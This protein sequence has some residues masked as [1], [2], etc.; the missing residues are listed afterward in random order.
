MW[1]CGIRYKY[2]HYDT[3]FVPKS[4]WSTYQDGVR[5]CKGCFQSTCRNAPSDCSEPRH[6]ALDESRHK[7]ARKYYKNHSDRVI[8]ANKRSQEKRPEHYKMLLYR[9]SLK[10]KYGL[11]LEDIDRML[12]KQDFVCALCRRPFKTKP[13]VDHSHKTGKVRGLL[14][15]VCNLGVGWVERF[16]GIDLSKYLGDGAIE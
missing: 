5:I 11:S 7:S 9:A 3:V 12:V 1:H 6:F 10:R 13:H 8:L 4:G 2:K 16:Q 15:R 14:C